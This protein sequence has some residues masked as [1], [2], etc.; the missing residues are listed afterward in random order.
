MRDLSLHLLDI[1]QNSIHAKAKKISIT[2]GAYTSLNI[3]EILIVDDGCGM[4]AE[5]VTQVINPFT[6]TRATRKIGMG[7]P[8]LKSSAQRA[9]GTLDIQSLE[10]KGTTVRTTFKTSHM[11]RP[12]L[13]RLSETIIALIASNPEIRYELVLKSDDENFRLD[14][15]EIKDRLGEVPITH[16]EV[17]T[18]IREYIDEGIKT[19]FGGVLDEINS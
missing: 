1:V 5:F 3:L 8:L 18:W 19:I 16:Y 15:V 11:D 4:S 6:T 9:E 7:I 17:M 14:T 2:I 12:P 10:G 13:G